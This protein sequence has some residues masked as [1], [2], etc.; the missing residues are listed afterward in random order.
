[1]GI[2]MKI[3]YG[4]PKARGVDTLMFIGDDASTA[5]A[6]KAASPMPDAKE[7]GLGALAL[8]VA[9]KSRGVVRL[10]AATAAGYIG[11]Q[12]YRATR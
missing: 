9:W 6:E 10:A 11:Y 8:F 4:R 7:L 5:A 3:E 2:G 12:V 1:M